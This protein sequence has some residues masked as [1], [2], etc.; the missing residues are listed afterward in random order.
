[1]VRDIDGRLEQ[2]MHAGGDR[3]QLDSVYDEWARDYDQDVWA[4]GN[5]YFA[6][7]AAMTARYVDD[8]EARIL[9]CG[10]G[11]GLV[12]ELL[13]ILGFTKLHGLDASAGMLKA[14]ANKQCYAALHQLLLGPE[15][16]LPA[17]SFDA[18]V[19]GGVL[20]QGH[21]PPE[22]LEGMLALA[23]P[24]APILFSMSNAGYEQYG[25][26]H[27]IGALESAGRIE[28]ITHSAS[29]RSYP[30]SQDHADL[31]HW[32]SVYRKT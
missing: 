21:A 12:G 7:L 14:A 24:D 31:K 11:T 30:Y 22:S 5:P 6:T 26:K 25:F 10:C 28:A 19:A 27:K 1:M 8:K 16:P 29:F 13:A 2:V 9:D 15:I 18:L 32:V 23:K 3:A 4:S 20:T 17:E